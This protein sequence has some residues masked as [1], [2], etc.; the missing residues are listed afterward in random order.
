MAKFLGIFLI[1]SINGLYAQD[2][3]NQKYDNKRLMRPR[4]SI[5]CFNIDTSN[6]IYSYGTVFD[7]TDGELKLISMDSLFQSAY[8]QVNNPQICNREGKII[9][10]FNGVHLTDQFGDTTEI[11]VFRSYEPYIFEDVFARNGAIILPFPS[12]DSTYILVGLNDFQLDPS[13]VVPAPN[14]LSAVIFKET[15]TGSLKIIEEIKEI[16]RDK[17]IRTSGITACRHANG[18][19]WWLLAPKRSTS[20]MNSFLLSDKGISHVELYETGDTLLNRSTYCPLFSPDGLWYSRTSIEEFVPAN[21]Y[22]KKDRCQIFKFDRCSGHIYDPIDFYLPYEDSSSIG[23][24]IFDNQSTNI[25]APRA[26]SIWQGDISAPDVQASFKRVCKAD[27]SKIEISGWHAIGVG[28]QGPDNKMYFFDDNNKYGVTV[29]NHPE[30]P[31]LA[32]DAVYSAFYKPSCTG[33]S[34][35]NMPYFSLGPL[36]G[37]P[38]DTLGLDNPL[39]I[40]VTKEKNDFIVYPNPTNGL[41]YGEGEIIYKDRF[42]KIFDITGK[43]LYEG[44]SEDLRTGIDLSDQPGGIYFIYIYE[45][46]IK[47]IVKI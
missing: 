34:V 29:I 20:L 10:H 38:C 30:L 18:R 4:A 46:G 1:L 40:N 45:L 27:F 19:D 2:F 13:T 9:A 47:K 22:K 36:D 3:I 41:I 5:G 23:Q 31:G 43:T 35:G 6:H 15:S 44:N 39:S 8:L 16:Y 28:F 11:S 26:S 37:S 24:I 21:Q 12:V 42:L 7:F 32:C 14:V 25:Y 17:F 33:M